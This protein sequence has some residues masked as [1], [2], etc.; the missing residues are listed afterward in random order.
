MPEELQTQFTKATTI[1][2]GPRTFND[3]FFLLSD[4]TICEA[5]ATW[6][7]NGPARLFLIDEVQDFNRFQIEMVRQ[8]AKSARVI[9]VGDVAQQLYQFRGAYAEVFDDLHKCLDPHV[10]ALKKTWRCPKTIVDYVNSMGMDLEASGE[11]GHV[12]N[13]FDVAEVNH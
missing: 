4:P 10:E 12:D 3:D 13:K 8:I 5:F 9:A 6:V 1:E 11:G 2:Q 7:K